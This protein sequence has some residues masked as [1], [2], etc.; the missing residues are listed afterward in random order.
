MD[1]FMSASGVGPIIRSVDLAWRYPI[2]YPD[3]VTVIHKQVPITEPDRFVLHGVVVS[4]NARK[5]AARIKE[6][7]VTVDYDSGGV[8][9]PIPEH[10]RLAFESRL[11]EQEHYK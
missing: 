1:S 4:H 9:A 6:T 11:Q 5:V 10:V 3:T 2:T 7:I 8:K